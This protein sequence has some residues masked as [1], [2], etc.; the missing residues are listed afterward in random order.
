LCSYY[1]RKQ[2]RK[3]FVWSVEGER[4]GAVILLLRRYLVIKGEEADLG[5]KFIEYQRKSVPASIG[6]NGATRAVLARRDG[7]YR[8][9]RSLKTRRKQGLQTWRDEDFPE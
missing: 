3:V 8:K 5:I 1:I 9:M 4:G 2:H 7:F 6:K